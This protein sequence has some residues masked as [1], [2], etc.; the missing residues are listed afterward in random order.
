MFYF[1]VLDTLIKQV[2]LINYVYLDW[3]VFLLE[4]LKGKVRLTVTWPLLAP[5][6]DGSEIP[7]HVTQRSGTLHFSRVTRNDAGSYTCLASNKQGEIRAM[8]NLT[9]AGSAS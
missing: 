5:P 1:R 3:L 2:T 6:A 4:W 9:V 8:V 7:A